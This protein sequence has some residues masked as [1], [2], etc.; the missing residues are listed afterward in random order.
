MLKYN[1]CQ[2]QWTHERHYMYAVCVCLM[3][4]SLPNII[5]PKPIRSIPVCKY[6]ALWKYFHALLPCLVPVTATTYPCCITMKAP[7]R[8]DTWVLGMITIHADVLFQDARKLLLLQSRMDRYFHF[9]SSYISQAPE[10]ASTY[11]TLNFSELTP[12]SINPWRSPPQYS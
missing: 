10:M 3:F 1:V 2:P 11:M 5:L 7:G 4:T 9:Q 8:D 12:V 6:G